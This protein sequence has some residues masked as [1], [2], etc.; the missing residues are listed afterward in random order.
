MSLPQSQPGVYSRAA[1]EFEAST[2]VLGF[3]VHVVRHTMV[4]VVVFVHPA[5]TN[6]QTIFLPR[7][8]TDITALGFF[9]CQ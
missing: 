8:E 3:F 6:G 1:A 4:Q 9:A 7:F 2:C 5:R